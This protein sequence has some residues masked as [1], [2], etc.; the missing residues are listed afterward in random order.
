MF[1]L[2]KHYYDGIDKQGNVFII[3]SAELMLWGVKI[4][5]SSILFHSKNSQQF[6][7][8]SLS[9]LKQ[10]DRSVHH[11]RLPFSAYWI[12]H[13]P[14]IKVALIHNSTQYVNWSC[15]TPKAHFHITFQGKEYQGIGY[16]ETL[17][18]NFLPWKLAV[19]EL[20][21]GRFLSENHSVIWIEWRGKQAF[22]QLIWNGKTFSDFEIKEEGISL[23]SENMFLRF[24]MSIALKN[25]PIGNVITQVPLLKYF[26]P[27]RFLQ[28]QH[29][30][31]KSE[32][33]LLVNQHVRESGYALYEKVLW[34]K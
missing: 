4:P 23:P 33:K 2:K 14:E 15:H 17:E 21:W 6:E 1:Y 19:S 11:P 26:L 13:L 22:K 34:R 27:K 29:M 20:Y 28:T 18:M 5:Y 25:E 31:W 7:K 24:Q 30:K 16:A 32:V 3:Y 10:I 12:P 9:K 8:R